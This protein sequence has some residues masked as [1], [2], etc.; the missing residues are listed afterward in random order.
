[1]VDKWF[2]T[3]ASPIV[4]VEINGT[5]HKE[6]KIT[7]GRYVPEFM[8]NARPTIFYI[9]HDDEIRIDKITMIEYNNYRYII[10]K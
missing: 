9:N 3:D 7:F 5:I 10:E 2:D 6:G 8:K 1:M 4:K